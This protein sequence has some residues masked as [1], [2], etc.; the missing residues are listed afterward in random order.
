MLRLLAVVNNNSTKLLSDVLCAIC[1]YHSQTYTTLTATYR[2][3]MH[4]Y[5]THTASERERER[6]G[7]GGGGEKE[8]ERDT[9]R[10]RTEKFDL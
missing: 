8:T 2:K 3:N 4:T 6:K 10:D 5:H 7:G 9:A 1:S